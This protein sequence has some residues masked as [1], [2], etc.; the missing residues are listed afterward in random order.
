MITEARCF[1]IFSVQRSVS[2]P[3]VVKMMLNDLLTT[4]IKRRCAFEE[5]MKRL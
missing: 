4:E 3:S 1:F 2:V 5:V